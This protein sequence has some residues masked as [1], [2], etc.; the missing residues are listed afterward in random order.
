MLAGKCGGLKHMN[1]SR[2][3]ADLLILNLR[4]ID[5]FTDDGRNRFIDEIENFLNVL[6]GDKDDT[7]TGK[8]NNKR[9]G[10]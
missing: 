5:Q 2:E 7:K 6:T 8:S 10:K 4:N 3:Y 1:Q 9:S